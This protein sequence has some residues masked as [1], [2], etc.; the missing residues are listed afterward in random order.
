MDSHRGAC[1]VV[2]PAYNEE[3]SLEA[4]LPEVIAFCERLDWPLMHVLEAKAK[5]SGRRS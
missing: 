4:F 2:I 5:E 3:V 1:S